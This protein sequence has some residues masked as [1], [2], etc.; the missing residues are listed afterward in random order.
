M[1]IHPDGYVI[2]ALGRLKSNRVIHWQNTG[3]RVK[4]SN[5]GNFHTVKGHSSLAQIQLFALDVI[6]AVLL[7]ESVIVYLQRD[8]KLSL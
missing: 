6:G 7:C 4:E 1:N 3:V 2:L 8:V 5:V